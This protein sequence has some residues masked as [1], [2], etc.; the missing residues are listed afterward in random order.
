MIG[1]MEQHD[2]S[3]HSSK[4]K[5]SKMLALTIPVVIGAYLILLTYVFLNLKDTKYEN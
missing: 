5:E 4:W 3:S 1:R 2:E